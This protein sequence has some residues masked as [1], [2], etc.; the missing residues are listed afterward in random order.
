MM[1]NST[2]EST[3]I[4]LLREHNNF[5]VTGPSDVSMRRILTQ[6]FVHRLHMDIFGIYFAET[7]KNWYSDDW[8]TAVYGHQATWRHH[9][10]VVRHRS[11]TQGQR[12]RVHLVKSRLPSA[13]REGKRIIWNYLIKH[14]M[15]SNVLAL[16]QRS[17]LLV[18]K[19]KPARAIT[20]PHVPIRHP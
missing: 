2:W 16:A 5:G 11:Y 13:V 15:P 19:P 12:Y 4:G 8:L 3:F 10:I 1:L 20:R 7:F 18:P 17:S 6:S 14:H 9:D